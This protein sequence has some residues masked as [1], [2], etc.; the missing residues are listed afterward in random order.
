M[1]K[2]YIKFGISQNN[3]AGSK[4][5][6]DIMA[7]LDSIG[8]NAVMA[9]PT[10]SNKLLKLFD[11]PILI[12]TLFFRVRKNGI[13]LYFVPSNFH[14]IQLL[15]ILKHI[16]KFKLICFINDIEFLRMNK[17]KIE[18]SKEIKSISYADVVLAPNINAIHILQETYD[19]T[20]TLIPVEVWDYLSSY[21]NED[22]EE[23]IEDVFY[24]KTVAFAGNLRKAPFIEKLSLV[25][26]KF[27]IWGGGKKKGTIQNITFMGEESPNNIIKAVSECSWGMVWDGDS[28]D[29]CSG[30]LGT[31]LRFN[32][33]HKCGLYL[34]AGIPVI[35]WRES[36]MASFVNNYKVG[37]CVS[38]LQEA[39]E[40]INLMDKPTYIIYKRNIQAVSELIR[41]GDFFLAALDKAEK[42]NIR[43]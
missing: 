23:N 34:S 9:L 4:A 20:N 24:K 32:N 17:S 42:I 7:L 10:K 37:I 41:N 25:N 26:L 33:S 11:I 15:F 8:Y 16:I 13:L 38:S 6:K 12:L 43:S 21:R 31:Y 36:G 28:I 30:L 1:K 35:V 3:N 22:P 40:K 5:I 2:Y 19:I 27:K 18:A 29:T 14:R 39:A